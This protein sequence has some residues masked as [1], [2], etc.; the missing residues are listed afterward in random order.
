MGVPAKVDRDI[1]WHSHIRIS[2][3]IYVQMLPDIHNDAMNRM[4]GWFGNVIMSKIAPQKRANKVIGSPSLWT[5][6]GNQA[7]PTGSITLCKAAL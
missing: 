4:D 6:M 5:A 3:E 7:M 2:L 1:L